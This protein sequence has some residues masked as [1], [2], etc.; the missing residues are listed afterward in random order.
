MNRYPSAFTG[1]PRLRARDGLKL[2]SDRAFD[3]RQTTTSVTTSKPARA[4]RSAAPTL[5]SPPNKNCSWLNG[6]TLESGGM[7]IAPTPTASAKKTPMTV[8]LVR[9]L[10]SRT[11]AM[12]RPTAI[13]KAAAP[14]GT[15]GTY[16]VIAS[17]DRA[18]DSSTTVRSDTAT[19]ANAVWAIASEKKAIRLPTTSDPTSPHV[20]PSRTT[21][22][23]G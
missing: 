22:R 3:R 17:R 9:P 18:P 19:P 20:S 8:S 15:Y 21:A 12:P 6:A 4:I 7:S 14:N 16:G 11:A 13:P 1:N 2:A 5:L 23:T 10:R